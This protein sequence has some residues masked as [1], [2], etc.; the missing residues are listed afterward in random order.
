[1]SAP[2]WLFIWVM[3][4]AFAWY[5]LRLYLHYFQQ[6]E[7]DAPILKW[8]NV[9]QLRPAG[10]YLHRPSRLGG[11]CRVCKSAGLPPPS[12]P[13]CCSRPRGANGNPC[14]TR[15]NRW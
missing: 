8:I 12:L 1:M 10:Q 4:L 13:D 5:R 9:G 6:E 2:F 11:F 15:K 3:F 7:Y 14:Q